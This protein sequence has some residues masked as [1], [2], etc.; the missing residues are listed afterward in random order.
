MPISKEGHFV[1][2]PACTRRGGCAGTGVCRR[3]REGMP[4]T[5]DPIIPIDDVDAFLAREG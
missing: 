2:C 5:A 1:L 3:E 4:T